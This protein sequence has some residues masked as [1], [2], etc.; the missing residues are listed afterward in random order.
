MPSPSPTETPAANQTAT[1]QPATSQ[2]AETSNLIL[3]N[4][5]I[6]GVC[7]AIGQDFGV[8]AKWLRV[9]LA[10]GVMISP[11]T[12]FGIYFALGFAVLLSRLIYPRRVAAAPQ[13]AAAQPQPQAA[14]NSQEELA[15]AA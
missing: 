14:D 4:D 12:A 10:G 8:N 2:P 9:P 11:I 1:S 5:T 15:T 3:R 13:A 7:E 6:L